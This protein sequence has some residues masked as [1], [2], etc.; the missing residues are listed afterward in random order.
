MMKEDFL[1]T[2]HRDVVQEEDQRNGQ[3][4]RYQDTLLETFDTKLVDD[5]GLTSILRLDTSGC[6]GWEMTG[7]W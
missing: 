2:L 7:Q 1:L 4:G 3:G 5:I 6:E